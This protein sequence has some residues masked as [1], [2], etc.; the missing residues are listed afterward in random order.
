V[1]LETVSPPKVRVT[2]GLPPVPPSGTA[3]PP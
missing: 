2:I 3:P 1:T